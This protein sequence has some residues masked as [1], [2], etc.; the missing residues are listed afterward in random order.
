MKEREADD[1]KIKILSLGILLFIFIFFYVIQYFQMPIGDDVLFRYK[2]SYFHYTETEEWL[3][4]EKIMNLSMM[5]NEIWNRWKAFSGRFSTV[6]WVPFINI[7]GNGVC[8]A[9]GSGVYLGVIL[10]VAR[11]AIGSWQ[12][13][14]L[15]PLEIIYLFL[16]QYAMSSTGYYMGMWTFVCH[17]GMPVLLCLL[18][19]ILWT[20]MMERKENRSRDIILLSVVGVIM[21]AS[22]ELLPMYSFILIGIRSLCM[23]LNRERKLCSLIFIHLG[24]VVGYIFCVFAPGNLIRLQSGHDMLRVNTGIADKFIVSLYAH[25]RAVGLFD[26]AYWPLLAAGL[27][28]FVISIRKK[29]GIVTYVKENME[30]LSVCILSVFLWAAVAPPVPQ[31]G[32]QIW[33]AI[34]LVC[35]M[36]NLD[37]SRMLGKWYLS[38]TVICFC[39][40]LLMNTFWCRDL[41]SVTVERRELVQEALLNKE[42]K[43]IV[44]EYPESTSNYITGFNMAN[45][46][47]HDDIYIEY[48]GLLIKPE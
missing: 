2:D 19:Y 30:F 6:F 23:Y 32:L 48:Y 8:A 14:I 4:T 41:V 42:E 20:E 12:K 29:N 24:G 33:K 7:V 5:K 45:G 43:V 37:L 16:G 40:C 10:C 46:E 26:K 3:P 38:V 31:Y 34:F 25:I 11:I 17:Y 21:G 47:Y 28:F 9:I 36:R 44:P 18:Y 22:H 39:L 1:R 27:G 15:H 35:V 13:L